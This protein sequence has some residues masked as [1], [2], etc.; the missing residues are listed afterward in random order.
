MFKKR[1]MDLLVSIRAFFS[2]DEEAIDILT[3]KGFVQDIWMRMKKV[4]I[5]A[6]GAQ[7]AYFFLL[8]FFPL[9]IFLVQLL[10]YLNLKQ[11]MIFNFLDELMPKEVYTL[12]EG[13]L[14]EILSNQNTG[15]L[16]IG[17]IGTIWSA[18]AGIKALLSA[19]NKAYDA[20]VRAGVID[21]GLS[22]VLTL[23]LVVAILVALVVQ[24]FG[25]QIGILMFSSFGVEDGFMKLWYNIR[26]TMPPLIIFIILL[27]IYWIV[28]NTDPRLKIFGVWPGAIFA[29]IGWIVLSTGFSQYIDNFGN[30]STTY[31]SIGGVI[32]FMLWLYFTGIMLIFGGLLNATIQRYTIEKALRRQNIYVKMK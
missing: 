4:D 8:S 1:G 7:L 11:D 32:I 25:Q 3:L 13:T 5:T 21:R 16:S 14:I 9:L 19:L 28:P 26:W 17:I 15:I 12:I 30:Y 31:G 18:S 27:G 24:V 10:P 2:V 29:T 22:L 23:L 6:Q 20:E